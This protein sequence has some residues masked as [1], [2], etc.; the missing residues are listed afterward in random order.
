MTKVV[1]G[2]VAFVALL[3]FGVWAWVDG[4]CGLYKFSAAKDVPARCLMGK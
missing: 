2:A 3:A 1:A 4:P